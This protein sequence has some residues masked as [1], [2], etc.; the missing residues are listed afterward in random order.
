MMTLY[1]VY[2]GYTYKYAYSAIYCKILH[3]AF[4]LRD[5]KEKYTR[6]VNN[7]SVATENFK[8]N[9]AS[10]L[11]IRLSLC[12]TFFIFYHLLVVSVNRLVI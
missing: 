10:L 2:T 4:L 7:S 3:T 12:N 6:T 8:A 5:G 11:I 9:F 1:L